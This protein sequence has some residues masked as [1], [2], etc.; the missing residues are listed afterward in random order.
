[1]AD[2]LV[3]AGVG[4]LALIDPDVVKLE[5]LHRILYATHDDVR[6]GRLKVDVLKCALERLGFQTEI[7]AWTEDITQS[8]TA[9]K[10][11]SFDVLIG[12]VD[13][14]WPRLILNQAARNYLIPL[15]DVGVEI[16]ANEGSI[17]ACTARTSYVKLD[18][19]CLVCSGVID[20]K[21]LG[22]ESLTDE[23]QRRLTEVQY[24]LQ[25]A[26]PAVMD[27]NARA[28]S[29]GALVLRHLA[30]PMLREPLPVHI[31]ESLLTFGINASRSFVQDRNC[32][33]CG[34]GILAGLGDR[35]SLS[36]RA[37]RGDHAV[38]QPG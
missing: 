30:Q 1:M 20:V 14:N 25:M 13:R 29:Y 33:V 23:E 24:G 16:A 10:L 5:N 19:P 35:G 2:L 31:L 3:R 7:E 32:V 21:E 17:E 4:H 36:T 28:S 11:A 37:A 6:L 15:I 8:A 9:R 12:C 22:T 38:D 26:Q 18:G 34:A 27:L